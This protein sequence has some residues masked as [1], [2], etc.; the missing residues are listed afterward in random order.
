[1]R[2]KKLRDELHEHDYRYYVLAEPTISDEEYD[3]LMRELHDLEQQHPELRSPDSPTQRVGGQPTKEFGTV[4]HNP[5]MLSLANSYSEDEIR[6]FD[7]R[8]RGLLGSETPHYVAELKFDGVAIALKYRDGMF[9]Q[10]ATRGDGMQGDDITANLKTI[11]SL[12]LHLRSTEKQYMN[13]DVRGEAFMHKSD[14]LEMNKQ[15][16]MAGEKPF[17]NPRNST[18]GTLKLQDPKIVATRPVKMYAYTLLAPDAHLT[19]HFKNFDILRSLG[20]PVNEHTRLCNTIDD[21]VQ[22]W[23]EWEAKRDA[24]PY[25]IDGVVVKVDSLSQQAKLGSI[26][27]SPRW[28]IAFKFASRKAETVLNNIILQVGRV[29]T[30]TPVADL[31]PVFV[32]GSTV[33]RA[34]LYNM[35]YINELDLRAGDTVI[36]EKGGDVIPKVSEV[37]LSKRRKGTSPYKMAARCPACNTPLFKPEGEVN[38]Y[39]ENSECP[40]QVKGRIEHFAMRGAMDIE[41]L[42]E[43]VVEQLVGLGWVKNCAD[44]YS[45]HTHRADLAELDRWGEKSVKNLLNAIEES[46]K[47][48]FHRVLYALGIRHVGQGVAQLLTE[49]FPSIDRLQSANEEDLQSVTGIGP[50]IAESVAHFFREKHNR[51][52]VKRLREAGLTLA[53]AATKKKGKLSG[54]TFVLTGTLPTLSRE[55]AKQLIEGN[56]GKVASGVSRNVQYV[57]AG[58]D[59]GSKLDKARKLG[60]PLMDE[61]TF[62]T[63]IA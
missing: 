41:G 20:L 58:E 2:I 60:V 56:G 62:R 51:E 50:Q 23:R 48:P 57:L 10:G 16:E 30:I 33:S 61:S 5:P 47:R 39:C 21:V 38:Y 32:G 1:M 15:R 59:A 35:D 31:Q 14:F 27:K 19:S 44:L 46:K 8:I 28:A 34:S 17:I 4:A 37:V 45:L 55:Q 6:E 7:K 49:N 52:I 25:D 29:G 43:A 53:A 13:I 40:A 63:L 42:G 12:P 18:A 11:R 54:L 24:L 22:F 26:A 3:K 9:S 36:V